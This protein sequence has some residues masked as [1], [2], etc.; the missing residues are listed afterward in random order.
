[1]F[2]SSYQ[3]LLIFIM[4]L[5]KDK[6]KKNLPHLRTPYSDC[7]CLQNCKSYVTLWKCGSFRYDIL[8]QSSGLT[9]SLHFTP[10]VFQ[11]SFLSAL[12]CIQWKCICKH[13]RLGERERYC[14]PVIHC[15][16]TYIRHHLFQSVPWPPCSRGAHRQATLARW[17]AYPSIRKAIRMLK[18]SNL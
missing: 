16:C 3:S 7:Y 14:L 2:F 5:I 12:C 15:C 10:Q 13:I 8:V 17:S 4:C 1:M 9:L 11:S 6:G 18:S